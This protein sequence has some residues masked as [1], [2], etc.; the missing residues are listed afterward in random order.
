MVL[1]LLVPLF[2]DNLF[3]ISANLCCNELFKVAHCVLWAA[4]DPDLFAR[5]IVDFELNKVIMRYNDGL[6]W[7][8]G[9]V[10]YY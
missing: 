6:L 10:V 4:L 3:G 8:L 5:T 7:L 1:V 2:Q 9:I